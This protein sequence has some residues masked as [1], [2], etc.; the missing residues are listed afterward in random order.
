MKLEHLPNLL[1]VFR[2]FLVPPVLWAI[3]VG[4]FDLALLLFVIAGFTDGLDGF[5]A[6][7]FD[8]RSEL[9]ALLDPIADKLLMV[10]SVIW[11]AMV[12]LIPV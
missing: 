3:S 10:S 6:R 2:I 7:T 1:C 5:L 11:L 4:R 12:D 8:W 9:G